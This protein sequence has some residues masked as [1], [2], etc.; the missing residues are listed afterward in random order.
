M[1]LVHGLASGMAQGLL[2]EDLVVASKGPGSWWIAC[3]GAGE[4]AG[5]CWEDTTWE[6]EG[7]TWDVLDSGC[8]SQDQEKLR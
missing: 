1:V 3:D 2:R 8:L 5:W 6:H 4:P 7:P